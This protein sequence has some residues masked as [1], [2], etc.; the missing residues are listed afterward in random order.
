MVV[1]GGGG[2]YV[3]FRYWRGKGVVVLFRYKQGVQTMPYFHICKGHL[4]SS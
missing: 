1:G 3:P 2:S 4:F